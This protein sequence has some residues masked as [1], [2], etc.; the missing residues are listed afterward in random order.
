MK[1]HFS[2]VKSYLGKLR[3]EILKEDTAKRIFI[4]KRDDLSIHNLVI[5]INEPIIIFEQF[6]FRLHKN[7]EA[8]YKNLL[9]KNRDMMHGAFV[10]DK[11]GEKV[12]FRDTL[13]LANLDFNEFEGTLNSLGLLLSE[14]SK[15][16]EDFSK[17]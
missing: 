14:Y 15:K 6:I 1:D 13:Q 4:V 17:F 10:L 2:I 11:T 7:H 12:I 3:Y 16:I 5:G 9:V 8:I